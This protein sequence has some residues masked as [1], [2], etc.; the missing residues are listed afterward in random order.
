MALAR[1]AD[2]SPRYNLR[3]GRALNPSTPKRISPTSSPKFVPTL[4]HSRPTGRWRRTFRSGAGGAKNSQWYLVAE[5]IPLH[6]QLSSRRLLL[7][8]SSA[9]SPWA[10]SMMVRFLRLA[11]RFWAGAPTGVGAGGAG[12][13]AVL[14]GG[15][16]PAAVSGSVVI[17]GVAAVAG[18]VVAP[19][20][21]S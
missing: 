4:P 20:A 3:H 15:A 16:V 5:N 17:A 7:S 21:G 18:A 9:S 13:A 6:S 11:R 19:G 2:L 14:V 10:T 12:A 1:L 8:R